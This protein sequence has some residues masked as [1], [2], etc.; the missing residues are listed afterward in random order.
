MVNDKSCNA[1]FSYT[2][3]TNIT[4]ESDVFY[5]KDYN[6]SQISYLKVTVTK[7][8]SFKNGITDNIKVTDLCSE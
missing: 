5:T 2:Q 6:K 8:I 4:P 1:R 7:E 3:D